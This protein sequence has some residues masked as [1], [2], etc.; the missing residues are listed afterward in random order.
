MSE[1]DLTLSLKIVRF[2]PEADSGQE[3][4]LSVSSNPE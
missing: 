4:K 2:V 3:G 1:A